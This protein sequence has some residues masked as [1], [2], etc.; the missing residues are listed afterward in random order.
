MFLTILVP[1]IGS[2][3]D[4]RNMNIK[5]I[6]HYHTMHELWDNLLQNLSTVSQA[7]FNNLQALTIYKLTNYITEYYI[8]SQ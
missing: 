5:D 6:Q 8:N 2:L 4:F 3:V 7:I 1:A